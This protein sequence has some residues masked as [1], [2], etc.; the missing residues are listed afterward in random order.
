M[1]AFNLDGDSY[2]SRLRLESTIDAVGELL[3]PFVFLFLGTGIN[4][5]IKGSKA[6]WS[7]RIYKSKA[8]QNNSR[9]GLE[10]QIWTKSSKRSIILQFL[11]KKE[12]LKWAAG[13]WH[14]T[15]RKSTRW[16]FARKNL[17]DPLENPLEDLF[18]KKDLLDPIA[19]PHG[20]D[21]ILQRT[22]MKKTYLKWAT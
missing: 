17:L 5:W 3:E 13:I 8:S 21:L 2:C 14:Y 10:S 4:H 9:R 12:K 18:V 22:F 15:S 6:I 1:S 19:D 16:S 20:K 7:M 11:K